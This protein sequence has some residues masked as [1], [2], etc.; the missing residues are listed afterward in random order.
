MA[1]RHRLLGGRHRPGVLLKCMQQHDE[2]AGALV[3]DSI[4][5][6]GEANPQLAQLAL[7]LRGDRV[8]RRRGIGR[9]AVQ[10]L[11]DVIIDLGGPL[12]RQPV[13]EPADRFDPRLSR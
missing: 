11:L 5:R 7:N 8:P 12:R 13:D 1:L 4:A 10:M 6:V 9:P 2:V 3:K